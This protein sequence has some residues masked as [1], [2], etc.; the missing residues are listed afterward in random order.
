MP[1][2]TSGRAGGVL[3]QA[4][5]LRASTDSRMNAHGRLL[6]L[7]CHAMGL[8]YLNHVGDQD[9]YPGGP[10]IWLGQRH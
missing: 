4:V 9:K 5:K 3:Q 10:L 8:I 7:V 6:L 2:F 1:F